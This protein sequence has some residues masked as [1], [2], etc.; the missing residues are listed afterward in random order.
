MCYALMANLLFT[1]IDLTGLEE[2]VFHQATPLQGR[3]G[4]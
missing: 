4:S 2:L 1:A 3:A